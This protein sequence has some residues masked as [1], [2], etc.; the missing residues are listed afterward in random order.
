[1]GAK[2]RMGL[3]IYELHEFSHDFF[4]YDWITF[5]HDFLDKRKSPKGFLPWGFPLR[6]ALT[7]TG[8][9]RFT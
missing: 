3:S 2:I 1:M 5:S 4:N 9:P 8:L 7:L 6:I